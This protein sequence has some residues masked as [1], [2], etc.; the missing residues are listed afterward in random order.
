MSG[1]KKYHFSVYLIK[2]DFSGN[3]VKNSA[4]LNKTIDNVGTLYYKNQFPVEPA[5]VSFLE[6]N[7]PANAFKSLAA[8]AILVTSTEVDG[9]SHTFAIAF[10]FGRNLLNQNSYMERFGLITVLNTI[11]Q[12][13]LRQISK[14]GIGGKQTRSNE[15][16]P[17]PSDIA[18]FTFDPETD[19]VTSV[20]GKSTD[21]S[22]FNGMMSGGDS[23]SLNADVSIHN[24][25]EFLGKVYKRYCSNKYKESFDWIDNISLVKDQSLE[26]KLNIELI[27]EINDKTKDIWMA[28][29]EDI[30]WSETSGFRIGKNDIGDDILIENVISLLNAP[31]TSFDQLRNLGISQI[32][33]SDDKTIKNTWPASKCLYGELNYNNSSYCINCGKWY[34]VN[35]NFKKLVEEDYAKTSFSKIDFLPFDEKKDKKEETYNDRFAKNSGGQLLK[36]DQKEI[37]YGNYYSKIELCDILG[38]NNILV[39]VKKYSGS[40]TLSHLFNQGFVSAQLIRSDS[41]F[42]TKANSKIQEQP[43][44][45]GFLLT[46]GVDCTIVFAII[47]KGD[48]K[49]PRIPFF[50]EVSL[51]SVKQRVS[52]M[53]YQVEVS[54]IRWEDMKD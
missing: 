32:G 30:D 40:S 8:E 18:G 45:E 7:G 39:H 11:E 14:S 23:L 41:T 24:I 34:L 16:T 20:V 31:L 52:S 12:K 15:Q 35:P 36:M 17:S 26:E 47:S 46:Y 43:N 5:W 6:G 37:E 50:S 48:E 29:P 3:V 33:G 38:K 21:E 19:L 13:Q 25:K 51:R 53:G 10:G 2:D 28:V 49:L 42:V 22:L 4:L 44:S 9:V 27:K 1:A 54:A